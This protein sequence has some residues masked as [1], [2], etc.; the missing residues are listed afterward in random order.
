MLYE[1][2]F[3][4]GVKEERYFVV[5]ESMRSAVNRVIC[6]KKLS[7]ICKVELE[8]VETLSK[9]DVKL[10]MISWKKREE[11]TELWREGLVVADSID[12]ILKSELVEK[13]GIE[14]VE[15]W[16]EDCNVIA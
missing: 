11:N 15:G 14:Q 13:M 1:L 16:N 9:E 6:K 3:G 12:E 4:C 5:A 7:S 8:V 10:F 2:R